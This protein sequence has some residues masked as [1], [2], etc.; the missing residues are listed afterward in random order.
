VPLAVVAEREA[1][2]RQA[3]A[4]GKD[5]GISVV[6]VGGAEGWRAAGSLASRHV[7]VILDPLDEFA[8]ELRHAGCA[9]ATMRRSSPTPA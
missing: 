4:V 5:F 3:L 6:I 7:A 9:T 8:R 2:I 1:D